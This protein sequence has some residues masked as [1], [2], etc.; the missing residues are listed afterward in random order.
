M[1]DFHQNS[2]NTYDQ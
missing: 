2:N 1:K